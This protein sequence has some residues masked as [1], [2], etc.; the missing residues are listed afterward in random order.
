MT[1]QA[2]SSNKANRLLQLAAE[3]HPAKAKG[4]ETAAVAHAGTMLSDTAISA[5][6]KAHQYAY[7]DR[8]VRK[9]DSSDDVDGT[10]TCTA[11]PN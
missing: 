10:W 11:T 6:H 3:A 5:M 1:S 9:R 4:A 2:S 7:R 8:R